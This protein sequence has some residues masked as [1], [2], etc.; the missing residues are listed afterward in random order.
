MLKVLG[1]GNYVTQFYLHEL[2]LMAE[3]EWGVYATF[4]LQLV[5]I[6]FQELNPFLPDQFEKLVPAITRIL[7]KAEKDRDEWLIPNITLFQTIDQLS[8]SEFPGCIHPVRETGKYLREQAVDEVYLMA[9]LYT[10]NTTYV[11][12]LLE[13]EG[14]EVCLPHHTDQLLLD[15]LRKEVYK[16]GRQPESALR[17]KNLLEKYEKHHV[18][19]ACTE[20]SL[21]AQEVSANQRAGRVTQLTDMAMVQLKHAKKWLK[22]EEK[23]PGDSL[24][25]LNQLNIHA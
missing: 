13:K 11:S 24:H 25:N 22:T 20:L 2:N 8:R 10:M 5:N 18:V 21:L 6:N 17:W 19:I 23:I 12:S 15:D 9:S 14:I 4:P 1:L 16:K 3:E 7:D